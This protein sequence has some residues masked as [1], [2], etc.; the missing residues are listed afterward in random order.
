MKQRKDDKK[1]TFRMLTMVS[2]FGFTMIVSL[3]MTTALGIWL[4]K[5]LG[6][7]FITIIMFFLGAV[8]GG[9][10][11]YRMAKQ[12]CGDEDGKNDKTSEKG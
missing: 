5:T 3:V 2:Q 8:A 10:N 4:D 7:S 1:S 9:Q 12:I 11:I 6:T